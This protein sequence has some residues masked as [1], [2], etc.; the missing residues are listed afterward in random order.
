MKLGIVL[1][2]SQAE[3]NWNAFRMAN[4]ALSKG[5]KVSVFLIAEGV[6]YIKSSSEQ[7]DVKKQVDKFLESGGEIVACGTCL[8]MRKQEEGKEC[9]AGSLED[10][11]QII[12]ESDKI[13][14]F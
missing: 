11:Y 8:S 10:W 9:P 3:I 1:S 14:T 4:L 2:S 6:E 5:D 13:L 7:F 12:T